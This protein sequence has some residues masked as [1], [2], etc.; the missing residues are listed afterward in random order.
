MIKKLAGNIALLL[1]YEAD[2]LDTLI[3]D[4]NSATTVKKL[5]ASAR[6]QLKNSGK[7]LKA[8]ILPSLDK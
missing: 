7:K 1:A 3:R 6:K 8:F 2:M 5:I 4:R